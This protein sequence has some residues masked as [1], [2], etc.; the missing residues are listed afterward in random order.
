VKKSS[1]RELC[2]L[3]EREKVT[4]SLITDSHLLCRSLS[5]FVEKMVHEALS[6]NVQHTLAMEN[7]VK[8]DAEIPRLTFVLKERKLAARALAKVSLQKVHRSHNYPTSGDVY[9]ESLLKAEQDEADLLA[10][11][12]YQ[13]D[14]SIFVVDRLRNLNQEGCTKVEM[15]PNDGSG[16]IADEP[17]VSSFELLARRLDESLELW[18]EKQKV[19]KANC[20]LEVGKVLDLLI[21]CVGLLVKKEIEPIPQS[22]QQSQHPDRHINRVNE[23]TQSCTCSHFLSSGHLC[24][25]FYSATAITHQK[26]LEA[27]SAPAALRKLWTLVSQSIPHIV[28]EYQSR[29]VQGFVAGFPPSKSK[30]GKHIA[31][32]ACNVGDMA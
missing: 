7:R 31:S 24:S 32:Q 20:K 12:S 13:G 25:C 17:S 28:E 14:N 6:A 3:D 29:P 16:S 22:L 15:E 2:I 9:V 23:H 19:P 21:E 4:S 27:L 26:E 5:T 10:Q 11:E 18:K 30:D 8:R 1:S